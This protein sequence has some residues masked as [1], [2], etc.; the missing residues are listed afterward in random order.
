MSVFAS[1]GEKISPHAFLGI[2]SAFV[3]KCFE[4]EGSRYDFADAR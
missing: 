1:L 4:V 2:I 3:S